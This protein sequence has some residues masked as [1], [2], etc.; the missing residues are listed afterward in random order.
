MMLQRAV[1]QSSRVISCRAAPAVV[2]RRYIETGT[3][4]DS[5]PRAIGYV[6]LNGHSAYVLTAISSSN[7]EKAQEGMV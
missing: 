3:G 5:Q 4:R 7:K 6:C 2:A 1:A